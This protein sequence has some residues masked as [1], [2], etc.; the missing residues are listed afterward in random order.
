MRCQ[1][2]QL[3]IES[4]QCLLLK[5]AN[6]MNKC[7]GHHLIIANNDADMCNTY[8]I[9]FVYRVQHVQCWLGQEL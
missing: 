1:H 6:N 3:Y 5:D 2:V 4:K 8:C 9:I 7:C